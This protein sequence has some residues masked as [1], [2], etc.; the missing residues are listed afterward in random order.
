MKTKLLWTACILI[1][2]W[3]L[4]ITPRLDIPTSTGFHESTAHIFVGWLL[5]MYSAS[6][7]SDYYLC[8]KDRRRYLNMAIFVTVAEILIFGIQKVQSL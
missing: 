5:G 7:N 2:I 4:F 1:V 6:L 8:V 3:R